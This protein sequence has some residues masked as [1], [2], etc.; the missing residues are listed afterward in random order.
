MNEYQKVL[1]EYIDKDYSK[2]TIFSLRDW[3]NRD[4][5]E[6]YLK[7]YWLSQAEYKEVWK[8][9]QDQIF[10]HQHK[11]LPALVFPDQ[12][13]LLAL[14]GGY[15]FTKEDFEQLKKCFLAIGD[16]YFVII[17]NTFNKTLRIPAFKMK[18]PSTITWQELMSGNAISS[19][20]C[21]SLDKEYFVFGESTAW[22]KYSANDYI[23]P[24]DI[25]GFKPEFSTLFKNV[26]RQPKEEWEEIKEWLPPAYK[27][28]IANPNK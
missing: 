12:Y 1:E 28:R 20:L 22:G 5:A 9:L 23:H 11:G 19:I 26:F 4:I 18:Y 8:T 15:L 25:I 10:I 3:G 7:K 6:N 13:Q 21:G 27:E 16:Q 2:L 24:L 14:R 17:Q